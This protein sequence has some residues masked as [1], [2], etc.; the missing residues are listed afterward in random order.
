MSY[1]IAGAGAKMS[2]GAMGAGGSP[3]ID[4]ITIGG[5]A[6]MSG[7]KFDGMDIRITHAHGGYIISLH[8]DRSRS[9]DL[10]IVTED[11]ELGEEIGKIITMHC[12]KKENSH[13]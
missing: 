6:S 10:Y 3:G 7:H 5:L 9:P 11:K 4:T 2:I 8:T 13:D 12:L 1:N